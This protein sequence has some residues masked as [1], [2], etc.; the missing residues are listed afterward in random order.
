[1][2]SL[3]AEEKVRLLVARHAMHEFFMI[4]AVLCALEMGDASSRRAPPRL[5]AAPLPSGARELIEA[6]AH[7]KAVL[8]KGW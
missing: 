5:L 2:L 8:R 1:M 4:D 3:A 6:R 7:L